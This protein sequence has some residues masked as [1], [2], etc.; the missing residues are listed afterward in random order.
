MLAKTD[1]PSSIKTGQNLIITGL[2]IQIAGFGLFVIA[3]ALFHLR[4]HRK[5]TPRGRQIPWSKHMFGLYS[6]SLLILIRSVFRVVEFL[7]G[8]SGYLLTN[9]VFLYV[10]DATLMFLA[11]LCLNIIHPSEIKSHLNGGP[12]AKWFHMKQIEIEMS[13]TGSK[14]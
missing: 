10:F 12:W 3:S 1:S 13:E 7:G 14:V 4:M 11:M 8:Q 5:T 9:E 6:V 2:F